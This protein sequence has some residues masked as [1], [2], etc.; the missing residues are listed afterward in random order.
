MNTKR[1]LWWGIFLASIAPFLIL[2]GVYL[3]NPRSLGIDPVETLLQETG[4]WALRFLLLSLACS[5]I[6]RIGWKGA[7]RYRRMIG[8]FAFFY[9]SFHLLVYVIGWI[10]LDWKVLL[11]DIAKRPFI[12]IGLVTWLILLVLALT[13]M[14]FVVKKLKKNW[15]LLHRSVY[16][17]SILALVHLWM[18]SRA[19]AA[20]PLLYIA[21][22]IILLG[23]RLFRKI[24]KFGL[25][26]SKG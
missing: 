6:K 26:N 20:E 3:L 23:E 24:N 18:Q 9:A 8:L 14:K 7:V 4:E 5:P 12:Y 19:S 11:D 15:V 2:L 1:M 17:A 10:Q 13:S 16:L 25:V 22:A 21:I